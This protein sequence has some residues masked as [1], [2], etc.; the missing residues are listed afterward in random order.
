MTPNIGGIPSFDPRS[1]LITYGWN[2]QPGGQ[3]LT[4]VFPYT[5][6]SSVLILNNNFVMMNPLLSSVF[7]PRGGWSYTLDK[8]Q[9][10]SN[11]VGGNFYNPQPRSNPVGGNLYNPQ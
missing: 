10:R 4:Q 5:P 8:P 11:P 1:I 3:A 7:P 2:N 6:T 9:P